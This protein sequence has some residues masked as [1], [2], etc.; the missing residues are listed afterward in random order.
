MPV[1]LGL[2]LNNYYELNGEDHSFGFFDIGGLVTLPISVIPSS[3]GL[4]NIHGGVDFLTFGDTTKEFNQG[5][6]SKVVGLVGIG[7]TY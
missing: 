2:S 1:K 6:G 3:F 5:D 7:L 4:W